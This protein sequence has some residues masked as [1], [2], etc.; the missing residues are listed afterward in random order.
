MPSFCFSFKFP[1]LPD[2]WK[3]GLHLRLFE[4]F[5]EQMLAIANNDHFRAGGKP[6]RVAELTRDGELSFRSQSLPFVALA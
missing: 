3:E 1:E 4:G 2:Y 6:E 5:Q